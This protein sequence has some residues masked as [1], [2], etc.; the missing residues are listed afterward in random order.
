MS[1]EFTTRREFVAGT[2]AAVATILLPEA[3]FAASD[4]REKTFTILHTAGRSRGGGELVEMW[5]TRA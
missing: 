4:G 2:A 3:L 1:R 5:R